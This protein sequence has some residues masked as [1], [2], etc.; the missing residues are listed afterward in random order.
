M[1]LLYVFLNNKLVWIQRVSALLYL[2]RQWT[3]EEGTRSVEWCLRHCLGPYTVV[4]L[5][6]FDNIILPNSGLVW[7]FLFFFFL[8]GAFIV[9]FNSASA[10]GWLQL[11]EEGFDLPLSLD[12][13]HKR[14]LFPD[15]QKLLLIILP[16]KISKLT[17][18]SLGCGNICR[19]GMAKSE[20]AFLVMP[21]FT[22]SAFISLSPPHPH[23]HISV[24]TVGWSAGG[25]GKK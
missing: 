12:H 20:V 2:G 17:T 22:N 8:I 21:S 25:W 7:H 11:C 14:T 23:T 6:H 1:L 18:L 9:E 10:G 19:E 5:Q 3:G 15:W 4:K 13:L 16:L 24:L